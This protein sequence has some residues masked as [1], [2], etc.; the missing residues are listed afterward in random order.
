[1]DSSD[2]RL[3]WIGLRP[4][5]DIGD[6]TVYTSQR[7]KAVFFTKS[8]PLEPASPLQRRQRGKF[9][10]AALAWQTLTQEDRNAWLLATRRLGLHLSGYSL[11]LWYQLKRDRAA[12]RTVE[13]LSGIKLLPT[14]G[15]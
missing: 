1:M 2:H 11:F 10:L 15:T 8:P 12:I 5:G 14:L 6:V 4:T 7:N 9:T 3:R 13:R